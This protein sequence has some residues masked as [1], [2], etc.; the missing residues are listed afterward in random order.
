MKRSPWQFLDGVQKPHLLASRG[1]ETQPL[2]RKNIGPRV[3]SVISHVIVPRATSLLALPRRHFMIAAATLP[4]RAWL[5]YI[6]RRKD[7]FASNRVREKEITKLHAEMFF[8]P[9]DRR[10]A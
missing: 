4:T 5:S 8:I 3:D 7:T 1:M 6:E 2:A 10:Q 9:T